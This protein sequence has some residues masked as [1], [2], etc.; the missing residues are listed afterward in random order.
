[1]AQTMC[2]TSFGPVLII[3]TFHAC[4]SQLITCTQNKRTIQYKKKTKKLKKKPTKGPNRHISCC[5][6]LS[7]SS[8]PFTSC[9]QQIITYIQNKRNDQYKKKTKKLKKKLTKGPNRR[10]SRRLGLSSLSPPLTPCKQKIITYIQNKRMIST[11]E[12]QRN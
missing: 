6:G 11:K 5:L 1:M 12:K 10:I 2:L 7:S 8:P 9:K 3:A 4:I